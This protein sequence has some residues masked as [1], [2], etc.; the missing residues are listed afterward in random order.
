MEKPLDQVFKKFS[1]ILYPQGMT[2]NQYL[3]IRHTFISG[4]AALFS[5]LNN[6]T[7]ETIEPF[8]ES[9]RNEMADFYEDINRQLN[10]AKGGSDDRSKA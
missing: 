6:Q 5:M 4:A 8:L 1:S 9:I 2:P 10:Q 3:E 7:E